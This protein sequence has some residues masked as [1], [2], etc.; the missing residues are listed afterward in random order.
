METKR[1]A[2]VIVKSSDKVLLCK[3]S[4]D[5]NSFPNV[6]SLPAGKVENGESTKDAAKREFFEETNIDVDNLS[7]NFV[8]ILP[9]F[10][11]HNKIKSMMYVYLLNSD[12]ELNPDLEEAVD[13][14]EHTDCG[15]F[16]EHQL[17]DMKL[18]KHLSK[19]LKIIFKKT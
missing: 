2:G 3:R 10:S 5:K 7:L 1:Y 11:K 4:P 14:H 6:W 8:G 13:G 15:Y 16:S 19:L 12:E 9:V 17:D 18:G